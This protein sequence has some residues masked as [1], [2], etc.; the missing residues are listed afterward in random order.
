MKYGIFT[1]LAS[2]KIWV[3]I[4][5]GPINNEINLKMHLKNHE[6]LAAIIDSVSTTEI[7]KL[8]KDGS[9]MEKKLLFQS[10]NKIITSQGFIADV[11]FSFKVRQNNATNSSFDSY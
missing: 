3:R 1:E 5:K 7:R 4:H 10:I 11:R 6:S 2:K 8:V 9:C